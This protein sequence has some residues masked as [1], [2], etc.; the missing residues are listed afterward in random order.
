MIKSYL[1]DI[2]DEL[3][4][5]NA[6]EFIEVEDDLHLTKESNMDRDFGFNVI[7]IT[8]IDKIF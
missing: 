7:G 2:D 1:I 8:L 4:E 3:W 6:E 5:S